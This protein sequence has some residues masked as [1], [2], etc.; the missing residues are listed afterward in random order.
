M[1]VYVDSS[2]RI[3]QTTTP[4]ISGYST[5]VGINSGSK[6]P[7]SSPVATVTPGYAVNHDVGNTNPAG[8]APPSVANPN[9]SGGTASNPNSIAAN[10][11]A[12]LANTPQAEDPNA[13]YNRLLGQSQGTINSIGDY[14]NTLL[15]GQNQTDQGNLQQTNAMNAARGLM[16]SADAGAAMAGTQDSNKKA[17]A[18][19]LAQ[20]QASIAQILQD[21]QGQAT[22]QQQ[23][24]QQLYQSGQTAA[25]SGAATIAG[26]GATEAGTQATMAGIAGT[27]AQTQAQQL[28]N[29]QVQQN[30]LVR[31]ASSLPGKTWQD[32]KSSDPNGAKLLQEN[33]GWDDTQ[34]EFMWNQ[35]KK[36]AEQV[37]WSAQPVQTKD[38]LMWYGTDPV[39]GQIK[40]NLLPGASLAQDTTYQITNNGALLR[41][42]PSGADQYLG[43]NQWG[44][45]TGTNFGG[46]TAWFNQGGGGGNGGGAAFL[47]NS[48]TPNSAASVNNVSGMK[49]NGEFIPYQDTQTSFQQTIQD[50][51]AKQAGQTGTGL[52]PK[53]TLND[54]VNTWVNGQANMPAQGY[55]ASNIASFLQGMGVKV[56]PNTPFS[57]IDATKLATAVAH[58]ETG[59]DPNARSYNPDITSIGQGIMDGTQPPDLSRLYS[60]SA[61]VRA[62]LSDMGFDFTKASLDWTA[63]QS[64][65]KNSNSTQ[66]VRMRQAESSVE[67]S[68]PSLQS[69]VDKLKQDGTM[70]GFQFV[71]KASLTAASN[72]AFGTQAAQDAQA[73]LGQISLVSDEL[74]Q[75]FMGGNSPTDAAFNLAKSV[76][77]SDF[78]ADQFGKQ[79]E[80]IKQNLQYRKNSWSNAGIIGANGQTIT[81]YTAPGATNSNVLPPA[82]GGSTADPLSLG[83]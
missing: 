17:D 81:G 45:P 55:N 48:Q 74:G 59:F 77:S 30:N 62:Y 11:Q 26:I 68:L 67:Q 65:V 24:E 70:T 57:Q 20:K 34:S 76:L 46:S 13:I 2:G 12:N 72:G 80:L 49:A 82:S 29:T 28:A 51:Q 40:E 25:I 14:F 60:K 18:Q 53:S 3:T 71:N 1:G 5:G 23:F 52:M 39:T 42:S 15:A 73:L 43:N 69:Y 50:I 37:Q 16:G 21:I 41:F 66:Q 64:F 7:A 8:Y 75:T 58:F 83:L 31:L 79:I 36:L 9:A 35:S 22:Q 6:P 63:T 61:D 78:T 4:G 54:F 47:Q 33:T 38:G 27:Q 44:S 32:Y 56:T 19:I 10:A